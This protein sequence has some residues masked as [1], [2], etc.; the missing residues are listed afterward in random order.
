MFRYAQ[1]PGFSMAVMVKSQR[2]S[3]ALMPAIREQL[4][5]IDPN[6]PISN[7]VSMD[8]VVAETTEQQRLSTLLLAAFAATALLLTAIGLYGVVSYWT[9][10][11][12]REF[13]IRLALGAREADVLELVLR[14]TT[15]LRAL[16]LSSACS[17][18]SA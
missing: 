5:Q 11:R 2:G 1:N 3:Q 7:V 14:Q 13:G 16:E 12:T 10:E 18:P 15:I 17:P 4:K 6:Q 9:T 8:Q